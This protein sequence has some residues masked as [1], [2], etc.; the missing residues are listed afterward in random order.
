MSILFNGVVPT[1]TT[2]YV[3][4]P[5]RDGEIGAQVAWMDATSSATITVELSSFEHAAFTNVGQA[6][7]W[8][9]SG[10]TFSGPS[11]VAAGSFLINVEN[12]RQRHARLKVITAAA[13][14]FDIRDGFAP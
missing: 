10:L 14:T 12:V 7:E 9:D 1:S 2:F 11:G 4:L 13:S 6:W 8:K 5:I 3:P